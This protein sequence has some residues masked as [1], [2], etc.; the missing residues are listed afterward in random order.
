MQN[1]SDRH[2]KDDDAVFAA[3][4][5]RPVHIEDPF[6]RQLLT[7]YLTRREEDLVM[8]RAAVKAGGFD[9]IERTG[10]N[11]YGSGSAYG[12]DV[13]SSLGSCLEVAARRRNPGRISEVIDELE[14]FLRQLKIA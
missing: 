6:A 3:D 1:G 8:L 11:L 13:I 4:A 10:H 7:R 12:L 2:G 14:K 9:L 5:E